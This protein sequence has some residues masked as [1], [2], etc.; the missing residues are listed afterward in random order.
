MNFYSNSSY[1]VTPTIYGKYSMNDGKLQLSVDGGTPY[2]MDYEF[3]N[4]YQTLTIINPDG[5]DAI[6]IKQ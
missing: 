5:D 4:D 1:F 2:T 3:S 6:L